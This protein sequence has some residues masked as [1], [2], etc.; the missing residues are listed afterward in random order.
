MMDYGRVW[1]LVLAAGDGSRLRR[2]TT[3][4]SGTAIP[5]Q[6]CSLRHGPSLL[7]E[8]LSRARVVA[9]SSYT[10]AVVADQHRSWWEPIMSALPP[11]N[12]IVQ[13]ANRGTAIGILLPLVHIVERNPSARVLIIPSDHHVYDEAILAGAMRR[14]LERLREQSGETVLLGLE[15][16]QCDPDLGYIL[17]RRCGAR[18][19][20]EVD[21]FVEKPCAQ[22][23]RALIEHGGLWNAFIIASTAQALLALFAR[24]MGDIVQA[25]RAAVRCDLRAPTSAFALAELYELLPA[26]DFSHQVLQGQE[27]RLRVLQVPQCGWSDLGTPERV[28]QALRRAPRHDGD[29]GLR[30]GRGH[31]SLAVQHE[32]MLAEAAMAPMAAR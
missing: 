28:A 25:M 32:R 21:Q 3:L 22:Q 11:H 23:A 18:G 6:F 14:A 1:A 7:H 15:P 19:M 20:S 30:E 24:R 26:I 31:L 10:C 27:A 17:P 13:P 12:I 29:V 2:L 8:A 16:E 4:P 9:S 5:K